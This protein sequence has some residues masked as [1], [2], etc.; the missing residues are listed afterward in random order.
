MLTGS[1]LVYAMR[2]GPEGQ[3]VRPRL[4]D[5]ADPAL[6]GAAEALT[7][8]FAG[9]VGQ[10][11]AELE[12]ALRSFQPPELPL[13]VQPGLA[14]LLFERCLFETDC[15]IEP[16]RMRAD[17]FDAAAEAWRR[18]EG[19]GAGA[20]EG[21]EPAWRAGVMERIARRH[22]LTP[23]EADAELF[24]DLEENQVLRSWE[25]LAAEALLLRYNVAQV[26]G[27][28]LRAERLT[29]RAPWPGARRMRQLLRYLKFFGLLFR[30]GRDEDD[31][32][33]LAVDGPLSVLDS[34]TRYGLDLARFFP[35][36]LLWREPWRM[37]AELRPRPGQP[38]SGRPVRLTLE[39][40][41]WLRS[42][43][44][45]HGQ[46]VPEEVRRFADAFRGAPAA[47]DWRVEPAEELLPVPGNRFLIP[48]FRF[49]HHA[50]GHTAFLEQ[51]AYPSRERVE[52]RGA[53]IAAA[54]RRDYI[55]ACRN[56]PALRAL[57]PAPAWLLAYR[58]S[59]LPSQVCEAL[60]R[61]EG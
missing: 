24:A 18:A 15:P 53:L 48:D 39:P 47:A 30:I 32:L 50:T 61:L 11:R 12:L 23:A 41:P 35:A 55:V 22:G 38:R 20:G 58:R 31:S 16:A 3:R 40:H 36:L 19:S 17:L 44:P 60:G 46:W 29:V 9:H 27:L 28:L 43:Y 14:R 33:R 45:D 52:A 6:R 4:L 7:G 49:V 59:L 57:A 42:H 1:L 34:A 25:P 10:R 56:L 54:G 21:A 13:R 2:G 51:L 26:Q 5:P 37:E 8:L